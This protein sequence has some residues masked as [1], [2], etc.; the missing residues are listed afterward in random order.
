MENVINVAC[1]HCKPVL[2]VNSEIENFL[3]PGFIYV[4]MGTSVKAS[5]M[6]KT[7]RDKFLN[8]FSTL[9][10]NVIWKWE[11]SQIKNLPKNV[12]TAAWWPQQ[13]LLGHPQLQAF[14]S[15]G[16]ISSLQEAAYH[17][18]PTLVLPIFCDQD[19]NAAQAEKLGYAIIMELA[20][21]SETEF[22]EKIL[23]I[24]AQKNNS[25]R[26]AARRR[27]ILMQDIP[28]QSKMLAVW[29]VLYVIRHNGAAHLKSTARY[30]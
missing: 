28:M 2:N 4:A 11:G 25:Y 1:I 13:E 19:G 22:R 6:P 14:I 21:F 30:L 23:R 29:W 7:L 5:G 17:G 12:R 20:H 24:A 18:S 10:F 9:P 27:R 3:S 8:V 26:N 16:G 15:H